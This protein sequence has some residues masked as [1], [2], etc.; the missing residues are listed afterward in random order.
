MRVEIDGKLL[1]TKDRIKKKFKFPPEHRKD[2]GST[3][4][5]IDLSRSE[6]Y[7]K[8]FD[9]IADGLPRAME[10]ENYFEIP[11][12]VP[13][14]LPA[15]FQDATPASN[16]NEPAINSTPNVSANFLQSSPAN[17]SS[18]TPGRITSAESQPYLDT[19]VTASDPLIE[20]LARALDPVRA[21]EVQRHI[22]E[23]APSTQSAAPS[24]QSTTTLVEENSP[25]MQEVVESS[26]ESRKVMEAEA[27][28]EAFLRL[29]QS[30][31][32]LLLIQF[33]VSFLD[34]FGRTSS[35]SKSVSR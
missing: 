11:I 20:C 29:S 18:Q 24:V 27:A 2:Q 7:N 13:D 31:A 33:L 25:R 8:R 19:F 3:L 10:L 26:R 1:R 30:P 32:L 9:H 4:T 16:A 15:S 6:Q 23:Y 17:V 28:Q 22:H 21:P 5:L 34:L 14:A 35:S 12:E